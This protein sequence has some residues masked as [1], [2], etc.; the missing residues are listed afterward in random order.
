MMRSGLLKQKEHMEFLKSVPIFAKLSDDI[1]LK[2]ANVLEEVRARDFSVS[3]PNTF[4]SISQNVYTRGDFIIR[5]GEVGNTFYVISSG[6]VNVTIKHGDNNAAN[7]AAGSS[8]LV[9]NTSTS[10]SSSANAASV[11]EK[12]IRTMGKGEFFGE[13]AL[14]GEDVRTANIIAES[15]TVTCLVIDRE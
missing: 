7:L 10:S 14:Q 15:G 12:F 6:T 3:Q 5:Q 9:T 13:R 2:I 1:I 8:G 4:V 11:P